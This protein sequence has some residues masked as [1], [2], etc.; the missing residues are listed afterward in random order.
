MK[1]RPV[2]AALT[3]A[4]FVLA[5]GFTFPLEPRSP[6]QQEAVWLILAV[7]DYRAYTRGLSTLWNVSPTEWT[8]TGQGMSDR[9][10]AFFN[11]MVVPA[12]VVWHRTFRGCPVPGWGAA[13]DGQR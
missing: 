4:T 1:C 3:L 6:T 12:L 11:A 7:N 13:L 8:A 9:D 2:L 10:R 5:S